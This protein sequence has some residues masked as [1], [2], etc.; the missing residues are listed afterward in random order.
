MYLFNVTGVKTGALHQLNEFQDIGAQLSPNAIT[1]L[2]YVQDGKK[3]IN[4]NMVEHPL[5][6]DQFMCQDV[7]EK[8]R[9]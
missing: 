6:Q 1:T 7:S 9:A 5:K 2:Q 4:A 8:V 3:E